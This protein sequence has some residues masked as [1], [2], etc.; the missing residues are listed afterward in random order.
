[1]IL[2]E[3]RSA[4][5]VTA[6][7]AVSRHHP[8]L[9]ALVDVADGLHG[10]LL[11]S[12]GSSAGGS[13]SSAV[14]T[15]RRLPLS[16]MLSTAPLARGPILDNSGQANVDAVTEEPL[17][18]LRAQ[19]AEGRGGPDISETLWCWDSFTDFLSNPR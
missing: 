9:A 3:K 5:K 12:Y 17:L 19:R 13:S 7:E 10:L 18:C 14:A 11:R 8:E 15:A 2:A 1:M 4:S 6:T 16:L